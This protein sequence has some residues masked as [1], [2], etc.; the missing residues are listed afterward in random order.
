MPI[1]IPAI[2]TGVQTVWGSLVG[3]LAAI[4]VDLDPQQSLT[5]AAVLAGVV[6]GIITAGVRWLEAQQGD[7]WQRYARVVGKVLMLGLV[8]ADRTTTAPKR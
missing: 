3:V 5:V 4:G 7:G 2:R 1:L 8:P 6:T